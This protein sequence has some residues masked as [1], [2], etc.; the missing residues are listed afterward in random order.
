[1]RPPLVLLALTAAFAGLCGCAA[2]S[3]SSGQSA[4]N[5]KTGRTTP[6]IRAF[7]K[8]PAASPTACP[9]STNGV[10]VGRRSP[11]AGTVDVSIFLTRRATSG[12]RAAITGTLRQSHDVAR[13]YYESAAEAYQEFR[14]LYTCSASVSA[15]DTPASYRVILGPTVT[16]ATRDSLVRRVAVLPGVD[17]VSCDPTVPCVDVVRNATTPSPSTS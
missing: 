15:S 6:N 4:L 3:G 9:P 7:L 16:L 13:I 11:W 12:E 8:L 5:T 1:M 2:G 17:S 14:R 10:T